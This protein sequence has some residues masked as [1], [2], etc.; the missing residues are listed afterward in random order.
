M[1][2]LLAGTEDYAAVW[3][4]GHALWSPPRRPRRGLESRVDAP[5]CPSRKGRAAA[6]GPVLV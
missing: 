1:L 4:R 3:P 6:A 2:A 5:R